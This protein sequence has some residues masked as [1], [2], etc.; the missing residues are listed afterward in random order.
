VNTRTSNLLIASLV[1]LAIAPW[2]L[3]ERYLEGLYQRVTRPRPRPLPTTPFA[4]PDFT[5]SDDTGHPV[6]RA[7]LLG[8]DWIGSFVSLGCGAE[9][10]TSVQRLLAQA[11]RVSTPPL[12]VVSFVLDPAE[13]P[14][15][16]AEFKK[17][18]APDRVAPY[19]LLATDE[20]WFPAIA[21]AVGIEKAPSGSTRPVLARSSRVFHVDARGVVTA[22]HDLTLEPPGDA[23]FATATAPGPAPAPAPAPTAPLAPIALDV[24]LPAF[25]ST[26]Q[27][28]KS[29]GLDALR[30]RPFIVDFIFTR[31]TMA[32]PLL[33]ARMATLRRQIDHPAVRFVSFS[34]DP[35]YD[36][37]ARLK[38]YAA[39]FDAD[40]PAWRFLRVSEAT[41]GAITTALRTY[42]E[43]TGDPQNLYIHSNR[44][45]LF[46]AEAR[47]VRTCDSSD[48][49]ALGTLARDAR[50]LGGGPPAPPPPPAAPAR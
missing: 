33:T 37:E 3:P 47:L 42:A 28:G 1:G 17:L 5:L 32:C 18:V 9:C 24:H 21:L 30:G 13:G 4:L 11:R 14:A 26:D 16:L 35:D 10:S 46:D 19:R 36:T 12:E 15:A 40:V 38:S 34:V 48:A 31:C 50:A 7:D 20:Q 49:E 22:V 45:L 29:F 8:H 27:D 39:R 23:L 41:L 2:L 44:F 6:R 25:A 43:R